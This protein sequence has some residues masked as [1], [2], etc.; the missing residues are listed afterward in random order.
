MSSRGST[1]CQFEY[2]S[3]PGLENMP[4]RPPDRLPIPRERVVRH[5]AVLAFPDSPSQRGTGRS[6]SQYLLSRR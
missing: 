1:F 6:S 4:L 2:S 3:I 5:G